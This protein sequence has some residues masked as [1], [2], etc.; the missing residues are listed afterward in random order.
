MKRKSS[1]YKDILGYENI[2]EVTYDVLKKNRNKDKSLEFRKN[3]NTNLME[4]KNK[5]A[6]NNYNFSKYKIFMIKDPKYRIIMSENMFDKI[7]NHLVSRYILLP[8]IE[9]CN[10]D[11][12]VATRIGKGCGYA[13]EY[14][15][16]YIR[17]IG[18]NR[19][20]YVLKIDISKYFYNIDHSILVNKVKNKI[21]DKDAL[22]IILKILRT[23]DYDYVNDRINTLINNEINRINKLNIIDK[24]KSNRINTLLSIPKYEKG[25]GLPIGNM[26]SQL[27][28][29]FYLNDVDHYIKEKLGLKYYVRYMDDLV[30]LDTDKEKLINCLGLIKKEIEKHK[31]K[32]NKKSKIYELYNGVSFLGYTFKNKYNTL[33]IKYNNVTIKRINRK[34][35]RYKI[36]NYCMYYRSKNSYKGYLCKSNTCLYYKK[37]RIESSGCKMYDRYLELKK[38]YKDS[39]V[40]IKSGKFYRT[41]D[42]DAVILNYLMC[43]QIMDNKVGFP[44]E[45]LFKVKNKLKSSCINYVI[46]D[47]S[48]ISPIFVEDNKYEYILGLGYDKY[49]HN[50]LIEEILKN[51]RERLNNDF[52]FYDKLN[53]YIRE[54]SV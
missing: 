44:L 26:T 16:K 14:F 7:V 11:T 47:G 31:L 30:I 13:F 51:I 41:Y 12:N 32:I 28:A 19:K 49:E 15:C 37:I 27:L 38:D 34:L 43:Y 54:N 29:I 1:L 22:K 4:I 53:K 40:L 42:G 52:T 5:L 48:D 6:N 3:L 33:W 24:E 21:K 17:Q 23:T 35:K 18:T 50:L 8:S 9:K 46:V 36:N 25:K 45:G 39:V 2:L 20:I 10:I